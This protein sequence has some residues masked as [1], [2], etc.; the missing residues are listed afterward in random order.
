M[1]PAPIPQAIEGHVSLPALPLALA[2]GHALTVLLIVPVLVATLGIAGGCGRAVMTTAEA[3][4]LP[5]PPADARLAYADHPS[6]F[7]DLRLPPG[8][9][10]FPVVVLI[11]GGCWLAEYDLGYMS[12]LAAAITAE[13]WAT[14]TIEYRRVGEEGG[15]WPGTFTDVAA[16]ADHVRALARGYP[17]D[18]GR[19]VAVGHS[20][21]GHLALWLAARRVLAPDDPLRGPDPIRLAG[22]VSLAGIPDLAAYAA[23]EGCG[24]A[25]PGLLGGEPAAH[26][27]RLRRVSPIEMLPIGVPQVLISGGR[28]T[29][30]PP[31]H[32]RNYAAAGGGDPIRMVVVG[33]AGHFELVRGEGQAWQELQKALRP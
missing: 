22:V 13:G 20:A 18:T 21:G 3:L 24:S 9:G 31:V 14:W 23:P 4:D 1:G 5:R 32:A 25:V 30:V 6:G 7:G 27:D 29:I 17:L 11:H 28:D 12:G 33:S 15:G 19:V 10:P 16:A 26:P 2:P 8:D